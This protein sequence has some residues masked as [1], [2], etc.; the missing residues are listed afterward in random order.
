MVLNEN[1][2]DDMIKEGMTLVDFYADWCGPCKML[3]PILEEYEKEQ[4]DVKV[5]K[6]DVDKFIDVASKYSVLSIPT[7]ILFKD[8]ELIEKKVGFMTKEMINTWVNE[9][10]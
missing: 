3:S 8:G 9:K 6:V 4:T 7:I 1:N 10:K 2:F 5:L